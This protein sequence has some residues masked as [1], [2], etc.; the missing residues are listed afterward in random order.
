MNVVGGIQF[1]AL[2]GMLKTL[3]KMKTKLFVLL[4]TIVLY[5]QESWSQNYKVGHTSI[6]FNDPTRSGGY[7]SGG[8]P[9]RQIGSEIYYPADNS[10]VGIDFFLVLPQIDVVSF[11]LL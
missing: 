4:I 2:K 5:S 10:A 7:G 3:L 8:G 11:R 9:G 1:L 6:T